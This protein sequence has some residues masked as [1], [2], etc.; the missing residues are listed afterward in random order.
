MSK[1]VL[2]PA[3]VR[4]LANAFSV[5]PPVLIGAPGL[6]LRS[7]PGLKLA[8]AFGVVIPKSNCI[9]TLCALHTLQSTKHKV[10]SS[11]LTSSHNCMIYL[12]WLLRFLTVDRRL[13]KALV[14]PSRSH[15]TSRA[16]CSPSPHTH[17]QE[18]SPPRSPRPPGPSPL[19]RAAQ[20][21]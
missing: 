9:T 7:S 20:A 3:R 8:N 12:D 21:S 4:L 5:L 6:S 15:E 11:F 2:N 18:P 10:Q 1:I 16:P 14:A 17:V 13:S 19:H